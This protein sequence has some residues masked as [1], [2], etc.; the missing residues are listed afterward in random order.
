MD[1]VEAATPFQRYV[2][3]SVL[4]H[5]R[6]GETPVQSYDV[7]DFCVDHL[8]GLDGSPFEGGVSREAVIRALSVLEEEGVLGSEVVDASPVGKGRPAYRLVGDEDEMGKLLEDDDLLGPLARS[9]D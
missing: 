6:R 2:L 1:T 7:R 5:Q 4:A 9:L 8:D 3:L